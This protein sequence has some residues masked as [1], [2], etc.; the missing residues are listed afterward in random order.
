MAMNEYTSIGDYIAAQPKATQAALRKVRSA[1]RKALPK[2]TESLSYKIP[3]YKID[4]KVVIYF[5]GW[6]KH[7]SLYPC[8][9]EFVSAFKT[10][11]A[12]YERSKGTI[13]FPLDEAV[14]VKLIA[15]IAK[16]RA[17]EVAARAKGTRSKT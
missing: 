13:R 10:Q 7:Y 12:R 1:I 11:L 3:T 9:P 15:S 4:D 16:Y 8:G 14:P 6:A 17:R 2:A 5:A